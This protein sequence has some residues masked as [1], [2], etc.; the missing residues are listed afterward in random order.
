MEKREKCFTTYI[1]RKIVEGEYS[2]VMNSNDNTS[3]RDEG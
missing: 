3:D 2:V 1:D